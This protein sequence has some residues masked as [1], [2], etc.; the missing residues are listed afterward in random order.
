[1]NRTPERRDQSSD[2]DTSN[3]ACARKTAGEQAMHPVMEHRS[4][5]VHS[6]P[7]LSMSPSTDLNRKT[8]HWE[9]LRPAETSYHPY[10]ALPVAVYL[11]QPDLACKKRSRRQGLAPILWSAVCVSGEVESDVLAGFAAQATGSGSL[12]VTTREICSH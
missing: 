5:P 12:T 8:A 2:V 3:F 4:I 7:I 6:V 10:R 9:Y 11:I 1:M